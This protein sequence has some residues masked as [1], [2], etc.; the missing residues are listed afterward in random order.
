MSHENLRLGACK[1]SEDIL[2]RVTMSVEYSKYYVELKE[3]MTKN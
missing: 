2:S 3:D 1:L